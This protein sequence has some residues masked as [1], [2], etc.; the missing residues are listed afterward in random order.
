MQFERGDES[1]VQGYK[2]DLIS[3]KVPSFPTATGDALWQ[4]LGT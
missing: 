4:K 1:W 3:E 2:T